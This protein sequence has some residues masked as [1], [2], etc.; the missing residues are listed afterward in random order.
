MHPCQKC[1][2]CCTTYCVS[3]NSHELAKDHFNVPVEFTFRI[4]SDTLAMKNKMPSSPRCVALDGHIGK[5]VSCNIYQNR[6]S[7]CRQFKASYEDGTHNPRCDECR[8]K[9]GLQP[10]IREDWTSLNDFDLF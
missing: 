6:P 5:H 4:S 2:A 9:R 3:F 10:L 8:S 1:G 7:P